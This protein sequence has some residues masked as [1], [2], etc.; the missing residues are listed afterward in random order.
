VRPRPLETY[1]LKNQGMKAHTLA[2]SHERGTL[3]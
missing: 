3:A 2:G 1:H